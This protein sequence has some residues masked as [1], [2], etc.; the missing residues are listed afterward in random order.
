MGGVDAAVADLPYGMLHEQRLDV[1]RLLCVLARLLRPGGRALLVGNAGRGG[2]A[3]AVEKASRKYPRKGVWRV[4]PTGAL[5]ADALGEKE[6]LRTMRSSSS[7]SAVRR[8]RL[9]VCTMIAANS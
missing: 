5:S 3:A 6:D 8:M 9:S 4:I 1:G 2:V 7:S